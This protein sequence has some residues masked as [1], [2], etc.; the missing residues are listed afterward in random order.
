MTR[1]ALFVATATVALPAA[2]LFAS[3]AERWSLALDAEARSLAAGLNARQALSTSVQLQFRYDLNLRDDD[4]GAL[5]DPDDDTTLGFSVRRAKFTLSGDVTDAV[6]AKMT[7]A[8]SRS[9]GD[10]VL[11]DAYADWAVSDGW[12]LRIGQFKGPFA[13]EELVSSA[14]QLSAE[15]SATNR[16]FT[17]GR[18]QGVQARRTGDAWR[19]TAAITDGFGA[20]NTAFTSEDE[21]DLAVGARAEFRF[22]D[23]GWK[24]HD[25]FTAWRGAPTGGLMGVAGHWQQ[26]GDTNPSG[27][28]E[29]LLS[30]TADLGWAG[31]GWN[32]FGAFFWRQADDG[33]SEFDDFGFLVQGGVFVADQTELFARYDRVMP[34]SDRAPSVGTR[35]DDFGTLTVGFNHYLVPESHAAKL[36]VAASYSFDSVSNT[37]GV[38]RP[39]DG[40]NLLADTERGQIGLTAQFQFLF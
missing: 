4:S 25:Q 31:D 10:A 12:S 11:E 37:G 33:S 9:T 18:S 29:D 15:R 35:V 17:Q 39:S 24:A 23:A 21:A 13:R 38:V 22:G 40:L 34:D 2:P 3:D 16:V 1:T 28:G 7:V 8:F 20:E 32:A 27:P 26:S 36:T 30:L 19:L 5:A 14:R 6:K